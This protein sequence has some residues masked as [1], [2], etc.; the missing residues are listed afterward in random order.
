MST[1]GLDKGPIFILESKVQMRAVRMVNNLKRGPM[2][3]SLRPS[4]SPPWRK[5]DVEGI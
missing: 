5:G 4:T 1:C 2:S 3:R